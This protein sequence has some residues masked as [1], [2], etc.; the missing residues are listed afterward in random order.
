MGKY[1]YILFDADNTLFDFDMCEREAFRE[2]LSTSSLVCTDE[3][4]ADYHV[5]NDGLWKLLEK[6]GIERDVLKKERFKRLFEKHGVVSDE[7]LAVAKNYEKCLGNQTFEIDGVFELLGDLS[8][9]YEIYVITNGLTAIQE[10]RFSLSRL[11]P[12]F[13]DVFISEKV[14]HAK[15]GREYFDFVISAVGDSDLSNYIVIGDSLTSDIDG[16]LKYGIDC[17][18]Y[19][20]KTDDRAGR[21]PTYEISD[22]VQ[23]ESIL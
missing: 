10:K 20:R 7:Y 2:A 3:V 15:P 5:I 4:Y 21:E 22:I 19:N 16:A 23:I 8:P 12:F 11:T 18:W 13:K 14:G 17:I 9:K 6:G 1:K